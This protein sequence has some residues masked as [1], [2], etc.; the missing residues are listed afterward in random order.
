MKLRREIRLYIEAELRDY[1][2]T[3]ADLLE[4]QD[5]IMLE[6]HMIDVSGIRGTSI[7]RP[8]E[9]KMMKL[10]TNKRIRRMQQIIAAIE[11]VVNLLPPEKYRLV[12]LRYWQKSRGLT[13]D[14]IARE[15]NCDRRTIYRW[16]D[17]IL[18]AVAMELGE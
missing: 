4:A 16:V 2:Q 10:L 11:R 15:L 13:D 7:G 1:H 5:D 17:G 8:T 3:K 9:A 6:G 12:E 18:L 14:G